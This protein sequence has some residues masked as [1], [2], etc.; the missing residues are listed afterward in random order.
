MN[1]SLYNCMHVNGQLC[2]PLKVMQRFYTFPF[3]VLIAY[4]LLQLHM[5]FSVEFNNTEKHFG[6]LWVDYAAPYKQVYENKLQWVL[7]QKIFVKVHLCFGIKVFKPEC[8]GLGGDRFFLVQKTDH[9]KLLSISENSA[10]VLKGLCGYR[11]FNSKL[12]PS[13]RTKRLC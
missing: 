2:C 12:L 6:F 13:D 9:S 5:E 7:E 4:G 8:R 10:M 1:Q 11:N 3:S